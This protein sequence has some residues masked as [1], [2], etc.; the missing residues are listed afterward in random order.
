MQSKAKIQCTFCYAVLYVMGLSGFCTAIC[1][2][3]HLDFQVSH[4]GAIRFANVA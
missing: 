2:N 4:A 1:Y 3:F